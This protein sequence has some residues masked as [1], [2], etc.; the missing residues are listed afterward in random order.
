MQCRCFGETP[1]SAFQVSPARSGQSTTRSRGQKQARRGGRGVGQV[2]QRQTHGN[3]E[4]CEP[5]R[6][7]TG[8]QSGAGC[9]RMQ[10][11]FAETELGLA[12]WLLRRHTRLS[13]EV[14]IP[15]QPYDMEDPVVIL[16]VSV[17]RRPRRSRS[18][19][20]NDRRL[21]RGRRGLTVFVSF[22]GGVV[23]D[24]N[25]RRG[26]LT[27][28]NQRRANQARSTKVQT[29]SNTFCTPFLGTFTFSHTR[30]PR[31]GPHRRDSENIVL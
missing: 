10:W 5:E 13:G 4:V 25:G 17:A 23:G 9:A 14:R 12:R 21:L 1:R 24:S 31:V 8:M 15:W 2:N 3:G 26:K 6:T 28:A 22:A 30:P 19:C 11:C 29:P 18:G 20:S 27:S 16:S 7:C